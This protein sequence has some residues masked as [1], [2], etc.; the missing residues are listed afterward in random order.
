[1]KRGLL[2]LTFVAVAAAAI[3]VPIAQSSLEGGGCCPT[4]GGGYGVT[5]N[6]RQEVP[7][8]VFKRPRAK[9]GFDFSYNRAKRKLKWQIEFSGLSGPAVA[10]H[11]HVGARGHAGPVLVPIC[12]PCKNRQQ[13]TTT[14][15]AAQ[16]KVFTTKATYVNVHTPKNQAGEIRGQIPQK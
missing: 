8:Q 10:A 1:V 16:A 3:A 11:I 7:K 6:A 4:V 12:A 2:L 9:G 13:G 15:T 14:L 5:L